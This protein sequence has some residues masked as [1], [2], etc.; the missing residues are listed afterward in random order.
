[1]SL[2]VEDGTG[3]S[4]ANAYVSVA[5]FLAY[6][7]AMNNAGASALTTA[8]IEADIR[9]ATIWM[10]ARY[11][12]RGDIVED[13][14]ALGIP[15]ENGYDDQGREITGL[16][17]RVANACAELAYLHS[18]NALNPILGPRVVE[19]EVVGAVRRRFSDK[20]G[21]ESYRY[22]FVDQMLKGLYTSFGVQFIESMGS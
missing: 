3:L 12:W 11:N 9:Y 13:D 16:P 17:T 20:T 5:D 15:T 1:M 10:D 6:H 2:V 8:Q 18:Q 19:Q 7:A 22:P 14:Q 21:N 4:A